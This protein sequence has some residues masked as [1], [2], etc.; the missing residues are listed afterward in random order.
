MSKN[1][2][3]KTG[4]GGGK[5]K[6]IWLLAAAPVICCGAIFLPAVIGSVG[7]AAVAAVFRDPLVQAGAAIGLVVLIAALWRRRLVRRA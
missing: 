4:G 2:E 5:G 6:S 3:E 1:T 7:F